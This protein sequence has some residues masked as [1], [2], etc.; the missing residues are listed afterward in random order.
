[1]KSL[2]SLDSLGAD[3]FVEVIQ[4]SVVIGIGAWTGSIL[5]SPTLFGTTRGLL[6]Q[7][8]LSER[9]EHA[10]QREKSLKANTLLFF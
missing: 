2:F 5:C 8:H 4:R 3:F 7:N 6:A 10:G 9:S 1:V